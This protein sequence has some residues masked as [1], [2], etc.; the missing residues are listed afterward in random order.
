MT[1]YMGRPQA[2]TLSDSAGVQSA[3][4]LKRAADVTVSILLLLLSAPLLAVLALAVRLTSHGPALHRDRAI[5]ADGRAVELLS[6]RTT[7]DGGGSEAH[8]RL[9]SVIGGCAMTP[10]G[11]RLA[12]TRLDL[13]PRLVNVLKGEASLFSAPRA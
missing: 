5:A 13:L 10:V 4:W 6:L 2:I 12:Q 9:R 1:R 8:A 7:V 11:R 3:R